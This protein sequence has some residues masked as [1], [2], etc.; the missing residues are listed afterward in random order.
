MINP[1]IIR[2]TTDPV[3]APPEAG[4]HWINT[5]TGLSWF[6]TGTSVVGDWELFGVGPPGPPG[7]GGV[8]SVNG[9]T[10][11]AVNLTASDIPQNT[12]NR[13]VNDTDIANWNAKQAALGFTPEDS[14][15]KGAI[16]GYTGLNASQQIDRVNIEP[17]QW[18]PSNIGFNTIPT[19]T[20]AGGA[21]VNITSAS[22]SFYVDAT[23]MEYEDKII[24][25]TN[26]IAVSDGTSY[27]VA[28]KTNLNFT[29]LASYSLVD[30]FRYI[31]LAIIEKRVSSNSL[32]IQLRPLY[33][34]M[35][36]EKKYERQ[37]HTMTYSRESGFDGMS[38]DSSLKLTGNAGIVYAVDT[39]CSIN[40][41]T[42]SSRG[43]FNYLVASVWTVSSALDKA[44]NNTQYQG[45]TDL[46]GLTDTY[47]TVNWIFRGV[48]ADD[49]WYYVLGNA[50]YANES[51][52]KAS[53][54][55]SSLPQ[56]LDHSMLIGR[57]IIQKNAT[58]NYLIESSFAT[59]FAGSAPVTVHD[60][61]SGIDTGN[62]KHLSS[63]QKTI[64]TQ[65]AT[66]SLSGYLSNT[67]W[68]TFNG[69]Q[70]SLGF[71]PENVA[72]KD[73]TVTL[74][75]SDTKYPSQKA[76]KTY[77]D[78]VEAKIVTIGKIVQLTGNLTF[79]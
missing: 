31:P 45:A 57:V 63:A 56:L 67:D 21:T 78:A 46:V 26:S 65:A 49:H 29:I 48:E 35:L 16:S 62:I 13:F 19:V 37:V 66:T 27:V 28:D 79:I 59:T 42:T 75:I 51:L 11:P 64:A 34:R 44:L 23:R 36:A 41:I 12:L 53:G 72:N 3:A 20:D 15:Q 18:L 6:S 73:T 43:F 54:V 30:Y 70:T 40:G 38:V 69:K 60:S 76:V 33:G 14:A 25:A 9:D 22:A 39:E 17:K 61:L 4:I 7:P 47:W 1:H 24:A 32:H 50:E 77:A 55:P 52:A 71:T 2:K 74:G 5:T 10:G 8:S 68:N 58:S